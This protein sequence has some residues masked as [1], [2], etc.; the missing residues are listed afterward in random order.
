MYVV[1]SVKKLVALKRAGG[2]DALDDG[3][4]RCCIT[5]VDELYVALSLLWIVYPEDPALLL[6]QLSTAVIFR[7]NEDALVYLRLSN[8]GTLTGKFAR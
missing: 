8:V 3:Q 6:V 2:H 7:S 4:Q 5:L 1:F